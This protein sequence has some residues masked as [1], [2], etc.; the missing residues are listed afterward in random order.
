MK[1][2]SYSK[3]D[4]EKLK[5]FQRQAEEAEITFAGLSQYLSDANKMR[6]KAWQTGELVLEQQGFGIKLDTATNKA[7]GGKLGEFV[8]LPSK[9]LNAGDE[10]FKM[11]IIVLN[12]EH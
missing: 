2:I 10:F 6:K 9:A 7:V 3:N 8:R 11:L 4:V 1:H 5:V 12:Q